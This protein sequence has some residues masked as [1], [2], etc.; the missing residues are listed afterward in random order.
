[1]KNYKTFIVLERLWTVKNLPAHK[2]WYFG[3]ED[4]EFL[5]IEVLSCCQTQTVRNAGQ[6]L[7]KKLFLYR[8]VTGDEKWIHY[9]NPS[10]KK[11]YVER[12]QPNKSTTIPNIHDAKVM[13]SILW[14][15]ESMLYYV[16]PKS[17]EIINGERYRQHRIKLKGAIAEKFATRPEA[18]IFHHKNAWTSIARPVKYYL[19]NNDCEVLTHPTYM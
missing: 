19:E 18:I 3:L 5:D 15:Q 6:T 16:F 11:S 12:G 10:C 14:D 8:I 13:F 17:V 7:R 9:N 4:E 1:M 2:T